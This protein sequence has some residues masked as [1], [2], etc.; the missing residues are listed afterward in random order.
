MK[1]MKK[2][3]LVLL[4]LFNTQPGFAQKNE[5]SSKEKS[6]CEIKDDT[7]QW[8]YSPGDTTSVGNLKFRNRHHYWVTNKDGATRYVDI[9]SSDGSF[10]VE[11][12]PFTSKSADCRS[13]ESDADIKKY[14]ICGREVNISYRYCIRTRGTLL[15]D[16]DMDIWSVKDVTF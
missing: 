10:L 16:D 2:G 14:M 11:N 4:F 12:V 1:Y 13:R 8:L 9:K 6:G 3:L 15:S 7:K 5:P